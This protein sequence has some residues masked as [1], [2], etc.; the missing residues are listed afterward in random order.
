VPEGVVPL[1]FAK[2]TV[3]KIQEGIYANYG[4]ALSAWIEVLI[5]NDLSDQLVNLRNRFVDTMVSDGDGYDERFASK[6]GVLYAVGKL[7]VKPHVL[8]W[9]IK[10]PA[11]AVTVCYRN[12]LTASRH[13]QLLVKAALT[14]LQKAVSD[15]RFLQASP[16]MGRHVT[17]GSDVYGVLYHYKGTDVV[18]LTDDA[19]H[20]IGRDRTVTEA[21]RS[22]LKEKKVLVGSHGRAGTTQIPTPVRIGRTLIEKPRFWLFKK[23]ALMRLATPPKQSQSLTRPAA[24]KRT[25]KAGTP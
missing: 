20:S 24:A 8:R 6:F 19:L 15:G 17:L 21:L 25:T 16:R 23:A 11:K 10:W 14:R 5:D 13:E 18:G 7:A 1:T 12:A 22:H 9:P 2:A 4:H 3:K